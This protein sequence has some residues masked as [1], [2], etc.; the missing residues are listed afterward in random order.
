MKRTLTRSA[1]LV[2]E[3]ASMEAAVLKETEMKPAVNVLVGSW[4]RTAQRMTQM[5]YSVMT[6]C[7]SMAELVT[8][9]SVQPQSVS[10]LLDS[11][12]RVARKTIQWSSFAT[13]APLPVPMG[14]LAVRV[15]VHK[16]HANVSVDSLEKLAQKTTQRRC[17]VM[18]ILVQMEVHVQRNLEMPPSAIACLDLVDQ[19]APLTWTSV[20]TAHVRMVGP[21]WKL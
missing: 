18:T 11:Q 9:I 14:V 21:A 8:R 4:E 15:M 7:V 13:E 2:L 16:P 20:P 6:P 19:I 17:F 5:K 3:T 12:E 10:V 1:P